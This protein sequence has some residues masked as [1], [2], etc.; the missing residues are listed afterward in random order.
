VSDIAAAPLVMLVQRQR[1]PRPAWTED[2][3]ELNAAVAEDFVERM[4]AATG[5]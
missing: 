4:T 1:V 5:L 3:E 2:E